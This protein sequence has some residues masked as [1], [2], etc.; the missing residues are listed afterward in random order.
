M[1]EGYTMKSSVLT[2]RL[3]VDALDPKVAEVRKA[4]IGLGE[5]LDVKMTAWS[6]PREKKAGQS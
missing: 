4:L 2:I 5:I 3:K 1:Q 6:E